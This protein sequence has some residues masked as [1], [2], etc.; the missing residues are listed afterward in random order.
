MEIVA[1]SGWGAAAPRGKPIPIPTP[2]RTL[3]L[4][5]SVS[6]DNGAT[7]VRDIQ[8]FHQDT[9]GWAD[10]AY[11]VL[12]SPKHRV[13]FEGRGFGVAGAHTRGHNRNS[14]ALCVLGNY[15]VNQ[16][17]RHVIDD[18]AEFARWHGTAWGPNRYVGHLDVGA[19]LCPG[20]H[21]YGLM[22]DINLYAAADMTPPSNPAPLLPPT[23]RLG[24]TGDDVKLLQS[25]LMPHDGIFGAQTL[26]ALKQYQQRNGLTPD[27]ICG[28]KTWS[29]ILGA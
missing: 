19:T 10:I 29:V 25:A 7:T 3:F 22:R 8:K 14:H 24:D 13:F 17:P 16:P 26:D 15:Q 6:A 2:V 23:L 5:H 4:H 1:R 12:Y 9:R 27:G 11:S 21:L 20:K 18:L 28:P